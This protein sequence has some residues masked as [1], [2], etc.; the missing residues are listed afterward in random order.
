MFSFPFKKL[1]FLV[2]WPL[3]Q[4]NTDLPSLHDNRPLQ[5]LGSYARILALMGLRIPLLREQVDG[6]HLIPA[7]AILTSHFKKKIA[8]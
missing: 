5:L 8:Q 3:S 1:L 4:T 6:I 2:L 7:F